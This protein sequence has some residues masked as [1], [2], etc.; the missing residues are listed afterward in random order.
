MD[1]NGTPDVEQVDAGGESEGPERLRRPLIRLA[2]AYGVATSYTG[3][4]G[5]FHRID[6]DVLVSVL[7]A[8]G[9]DASTPQKID[10]AVN[11][12]EEVGATRLCPPTVLQVE[13]E[14]TSVT[15]PG[16]SDQVKVGLTLEDGST[17][18]GKLGVGRAGGPSAPLALTLPVGIPIGYHTIHIE[19][20]ERMADATLMVSPRRIPLPDS[21]LDHRRWGW[22]VQLYSVRSHRSWGVGDYADLSL[23]LSEAGEKTGAD[24]ML[25]NP[26]HAAEPVTPLTPSPYFPDS[27]EFLNASYIRPEEIPE[28]DGLPPEDRSR[29]DALKA[30]AA[31]GNRNPDFL[32]RDAMWEA[33]RQALEIVFSQGLTD[34]GR[35]EAFEAFKRA[36]GVELDAYALWCTAYQWWGAPRDGGDSWFT[37]YG[38]SSPRVKALAREHPETV[39]FN[40]WLQWVAE[41]QLGQAQ[42]AARRS[43]MS[44][45]LME[46][47]A[48]GVDPVGSDV[49][50][51]PELFAG[52]A[53]VGA[54]PD[55]FNQQ[56]Q[57][58]LQ[59]PLNPITLEETG[60]EAY[61]RLVHGMFSHCGA[62]RVDHALGLFRL[63]WIPRGQSA[64]RGTYVTYRHDA[65]LAVLAI[66][67]T[68]AHGVVIG[69]D[70]GVVPPHVA[71]ALAGRGVLGTIIEWFEQEDGVFRDPATY[72]RYALAAVTTHDMPPT[73]G[74]LD[75]EQVKVRDR[76]HL[77]TQPVEEFQAAARREHE[78]M[79]DFLV[80]G[81]WLDASALEDERAHEQEIVEAMHRALLRSPSLLLAA[82]L[83]DG[84]GERRTQNQP[85]T[86]DEYPNWRVPLADGDRNPVYAE[87]VFS[88]PRVQS[89]SKV[90]RG[91]EDLARRAG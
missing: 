82:S 38:P 89:L 45:G 22:T 91:G 21:L 31:A 77:L 29:V 28:Y 56:G 36:G 5:E 35:R 71:S 73:A 3:Q 74:Y 52:G 43:G 34:A 83:A 79:M 72:R 14:E 69:E 12:A 57:N 44:I 50:S 90:M 63:W 68:R 16:A 6:D 48:V 32:D 61:R 65:M 87:D 10:A 1:V 46:D 76:L 27:R 25:I 60:Y 67:A 88:S 19:D 58:W 84:V 86:V 51:H 8:L 64:A 24:F 70:L 59:P 37:R 15:L 30:K 17:Y 85:G 54:P 75:Y 9:I 62:I 41:E 26:V 47:M 39:E 18:R 55:F 42:L 20:G 78:G 80:K 33:K 40:R 2:K 11:R 7:A 81:G 23:L 13:G 66:E 4:Q 49:W 53:T